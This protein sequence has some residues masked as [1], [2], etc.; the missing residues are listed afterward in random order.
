VKIKRATL[1][2]EESLAE[3]LITPV[4]VANY[5]PSVRP[6]VALSGLIHL[7]ISQEVKAIAFRHFAA[8]IL[9][10]TY[11]RDFILQLNNNAKLCK[12]LGSTRILITMY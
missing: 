6:T 5:L 8:I 7:K 4:S 12:F 1:A 11:Q 3:R 2:G 10:R 9:L